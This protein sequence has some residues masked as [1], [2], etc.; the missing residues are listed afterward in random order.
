MSTTPKVNGLLQVI[1]DGESCRIPPAGLLVVC[2]GIVYGDPSETTPQGLAT[3]RL[4]LD[5]ILILA[6]D[7]GFTQYDVLHAL[8]A[9]NQPSHRISLMA[10]AA[11]EAAGYGDM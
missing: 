9:R 1:P 8:L 3:A 10:Q 11:C 4:L 7:A 2:A 5:G 6:R